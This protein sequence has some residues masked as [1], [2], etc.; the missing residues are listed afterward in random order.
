MSE[1]TQWL[2]SHG[3]SMAVLEIIVFI[4]ILAT[5]VNLSRYFIGFKS[6]GIYAPVILALAYR[7]TGLRYG[8]IITLL[9]VIAAF[10]GYSVLKR[11]RMHYLA[12]VAI[13]YVIVA[14]VVVFGIATFDS[15]NPLGFDNFESVNPLALISIVALSDFFIKMYVKKSITATARVLLETV[16][17]A[18]IGW[19]LISAQSMIEYLVNNLWM[20][21]VFLILNLIIGRYTGLR[22]KE[23]FR[24]S[25]IIKN[26]NK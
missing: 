18:V 14:L 25:F 15:L 13:N 2:L 6:F 1:L 4:P 7:Y 22:I 16:L 26:E 24:F 19:S 12:R 8:L 21:G 10:I 9:V 17:I 11:I 5:L 20:L 23:Y 3:I